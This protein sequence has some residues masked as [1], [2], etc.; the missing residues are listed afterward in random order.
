MMMSRDEDDDERS[1][2]PSSIN[3]I[4]IIILILIIMRGSGFP[5][6]SSF[7]RFQSVTLL[8]I[9][10]S[11][12]PVQSGE[13]IRI[14]Y[15]SAF[16]SCIII[17]IVIMIFFFFTYKT[18]GDRDHVSF[19]QGIEISVTWDTKN[20]VV[21]KN[22]PEIPILMF[23]LELLLRARFPFLNSFSRVTI[24]SFFGVGCRT[25]GTWYCLGMRETEEGAKKSLIKDGW[26]R[27][28]G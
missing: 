7:S 8:K 3:F 11:R 26:L 1:H 22:V 12:T 15:V 25:V 5:L 21:E 20:V 10:E 17:I 24:R 9:T 19:S 6:F 4:P 28:W 27:V 14:E 2:H 13:R 18:D 23:S 16:P